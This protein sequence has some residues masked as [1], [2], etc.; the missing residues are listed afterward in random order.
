ML[1]ML[2]TDICSYII[3]NKP[4]AAADKFAKVDSN[5]LSISAVTYFELLYG[6]R[7]VST[8]RINEGVIENFVSN[9][10]V[11]DWD[12]DAA[13]FASAIKLNLIKKGMRIEDGDILIAGHAMS[14]GATL[15]TNN[16]RDFSRIKGLKIE[17]WV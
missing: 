11:M 9:F 3:K 10:Q 6:A 7:K 4:A 1:Y 16:R 13:N 14:L 8:S 5:D 12:R 15:V 17:N 2:D